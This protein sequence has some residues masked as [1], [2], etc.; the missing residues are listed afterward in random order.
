MPRPVTIRTVARMAGCSIATVSR[1]MNGTGPASVEAETRVR[2]AVAELGFR[3][4]EIGRSLK[5]LRTRTLGVVIPSLTNPVFAS[6]VAGIEAEARKH[7]HVLLVTA[8]DYDPGR[9]RELVDT[10]VAQSVAGLVMTVADPDSNPTLDHLDTA[11]IPYVLVYNEPQRSGRA[12]VTV[13][14]AA[15][16]RTLTRA[17][18]DKGHARILFV[19]GR[20]SSSDRSRLRY[21]GYALAMR[22]AGLQAAPV[23]ELD[24]LADVAAHRVALETLFAVQPCPSALICSNDLLALSIAAAVRDMGLRVPQDISVAGF[25][26]ISIGRLVSPSLCTIDQPT[27]LMGERAVQRLFELI[28]CTGLRAVEHLPFRLRLGESIAAAPEDTGI[29]PL[30]TLTA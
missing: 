5:T 30:A 21:R 9:E 17:F 28:A 23:L 20:F 22:E 3:P 29:G 26:G 18:I 16:G 10:L 11:G 1:V 19:G 6:S 2:A 12:A 7:G 27:R 24:Y 25:D 14:N 13:D 4:S 8:T 15:S